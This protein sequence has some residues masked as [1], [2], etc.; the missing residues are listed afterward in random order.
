[1]PDEV[2]VDGMKFMQ[3]I[4]YTTSKP[5]EVQKAMD[6]FFA[7]TEGRRTV[8]HGH[9]GHDRD[10]DDKY[11]NVVIFDS[12]EEAMKNNELPETQAFAAQMMTLCGDVTFHNLD[13]IRDEGARNP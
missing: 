2:E 5:D 11:V 13:V 9:M 3:I 1:M 7:K 8:G 6:D 10:Q 4:E 12:Y